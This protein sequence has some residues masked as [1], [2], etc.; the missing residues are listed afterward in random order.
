VVALVLPIDLDLDFVP[1]V[2]ATRRRAA[3]RSVL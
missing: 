2:E 1:V 3:N